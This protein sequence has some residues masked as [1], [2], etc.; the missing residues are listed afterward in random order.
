MGG[1]LFDILGE[2]IWPTQRRDNGVVIIVYLKLICDFMFYM[3]EYYGNDE[4]K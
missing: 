4:K 3:I 1:G 2:H